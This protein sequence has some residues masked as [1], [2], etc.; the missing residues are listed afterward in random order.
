M[1]IVDF[2]DF[3]L[4]FKALRDQGYEVIGPT[5]RDG[6]IVL[7]SVSSVEDLPGGWTDV[8]SGGSYSLERRSD[9]ALFGYVV[10]PFSWKRFLYQPRLRLFSAMRSGRELKFSADA[11]DNPG[12]VR[13]FAFLGVRPC[14]VQAIAIH[15]KVFLDG[16]YADP[17]YAALRSGALIIA[18]NCVE[19][20]GN[21]FCASMGTGP[22]AESGFDLSLTE[23][24]GNG[25]HRFVITAATGRGEAILDA[26]PH[27]AASAEERHHADALLEGAAEHMGRT[28][29]VDR[30]KQTLYENFDNP[31]WESVN[32]RCLACANCTMVCPTC[33]CSTVEDVTDLGGGRA[34]RWRRWDSCFTM[35]FAKVAGGNTRPST[36][37]RYRQWLMH[38]LGYWN[39]QFG[40]S[41]CVGCGRC[42]TW[43]PVGIDITEEAA[44]LQGGETA[45]TAGAEAAR[46]RT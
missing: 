45:K 40:V 43:C 2:K 44:V 13:K 11:A 17:N 28:L 46:P 35:E 32:K 8:Q 36:M 7:D 29:K 3:H 27:H 19:P 26:V 23:L 9:E 34:E 21:C 16:N 37:A 14:E 30:L 10:G 5:V 33:F 25:A 24:V 15:D 42:I 39:D 41:G 18:V 12:N 38:K 1:H 6:A 31:E 4:L 20:G 22:K